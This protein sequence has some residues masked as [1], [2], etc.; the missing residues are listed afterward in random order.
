MNK[1]L[2]FS[3]WE[4]LKANPKL[5][6]KA[7]VF[8]VVG[9]AG[10]VVVVSLGIWAGVSAIGYVASSASKVVQSPIAQ[11]HFDNLSAELKE[12][13]AFQPASCW[14][15][16]YSLLAVQPWLERPAIDNLTHL[17]MAC[18]MKETKT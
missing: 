1:Y 5:L 4:K 9:I 6:K 2:L 7:K 12:F 17:K 14:E 15:M 10:F 13:P 11:S 18:F 16:S 8:V 3:I